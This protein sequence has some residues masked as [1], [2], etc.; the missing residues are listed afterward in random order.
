MRI[1]EIILV[2]KTKKY[3]CPTTNPQAKPLV[4]SEQPSRQNTNKL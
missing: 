2:E 4:S 3:T 1:S